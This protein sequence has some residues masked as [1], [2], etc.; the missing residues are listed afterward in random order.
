MALARRVTP[1]TRALSRDSCEPRR[2]NGGARL[3]STRPALPASRYRYLSQACTAQPTAYREVPPLRPSPYSSSASATASTSVSCWRG[4]AWAPLPLTGPPLEAL[5]S[6]GG[7][8]SAVSRLRGGRAGHGCSLVPPR[9]AWPARYMASSAR[10]PGGRCTRPRPPPR[11]A[12]VLRRTAA[13]AGAHDETDSAVLPPLRPP[14]PSIPPS[15]RRSAASALCFF[16]LS[17]PPSFTH[18]P[19][20]KFLPPKVA[21]VRRPRIEFFPLPPSRPSSFIYCG[22]SLSKP[23]FSPLHLPPPVLVLRPRTASQIPTLL[24]RGRPSS[25]SPDH[26]THIQ[27]HSMSSIPYFPMTSIN[28]D[29]TAVTL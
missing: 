6:A 8:H 20:S 29:A 19:L 5:G 22:F 12:P 17:L 13:L 23:V 25:L 24:P 18:A 27:N 26:P 14:P 7:Q 28:I 16:F 1:A 10:R 11:P 4:R 2:A 9:R 15:H 3:A 21:S